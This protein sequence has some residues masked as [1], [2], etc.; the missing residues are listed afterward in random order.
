MEL[1]RA[2]KRYKKGLAKRFTKE[3]GRKQFNYY[4]DRA[5]IT[6]LRLQARHLEV[7]IYVL[8]EHCLQLGLAEVYAMTQDEALK[9]QLCRHLVQDH[10]LTPITKPESEPLTRRVLQLENAMHFLELL[11]TRN[12]REEQKEIISALMKKTQV[13]GDNS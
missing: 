8:C 9:D 1:I 5:L 11:E 7:P 2:V 10:L 3:I 13:E 6:L 4:T 12:N